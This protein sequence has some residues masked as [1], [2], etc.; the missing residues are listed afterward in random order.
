MFGGSI[1]GS[2]EKGYYKM[3]NVQ[4]VKYCGNCKHFIPHKSDL[5]LST[6]AVIFK[7]ASLVVQEM[8]KNQYCEVCRSENQRCGPT[9]LLYEEQEEQSI[10]SQRASLAEIRKVHSL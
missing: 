8:P 10:D 3:S 6:C 9:G 1:S 5:T 4:Q 2:T 7:Y